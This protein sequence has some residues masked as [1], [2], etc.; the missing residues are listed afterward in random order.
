MTSTRAT[1][2]G[3]QR[4]LREGA[5]GRAV[6]VDRVGVE[7]AVHTRPRLEGRQGHELPGTGNRER[8]QHERVE[9]AAHCR[10]RAN[11]QRQ[12]DDDDQ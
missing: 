4:Q 10:C 5:L 1:A 7:V 8:S 11:S 6:R 3:V 12:R 2:A 9:Q